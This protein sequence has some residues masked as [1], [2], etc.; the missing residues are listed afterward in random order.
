[1]KIGQLLGLVLVSVVVS[2]CWSHSMSG[3]DN[4]P[5]YKTYKT[6]G[7]V[8]DVYVRLTSHDSGCLAT[9]S[10][11]YSPERND[12]HIYYGAIGYYHDSAY[13]TAGSDGDVVIK[14]RAPPGGG[15]YS[16]IAMH[17]LETG[18]CK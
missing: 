3:A 2:G 7:T 14:F 10:T 8:K 12:F 16:E 17:L 5:I 9:M 1:M 18:S 13:G 4:E 6:K 11:Q 15:R